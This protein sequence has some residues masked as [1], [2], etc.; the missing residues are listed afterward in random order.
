MVV[1]STGYGVTRPHLCL[2]SVRRQTGVVREH[3]YVDAAQQ[4]PP[5]PALENLLHLTR[6]L[7]PETIV[8][9]L[10]LDDWLARPD[11][12]AMVYEAHADGAWVTYGSY[13]TADGLPGLSAGVNVAACRA[14]PW[15]A[16][17]LKSYRAGL[18]HRIRPADLQDVGGAWLTN[19]RDVAVMLPCLEMAGQDR[20]VFVDE[21]L[22]IYNSA[23]SYEANHGLAGLAAERA[24][25]AYVRGLEPYERLESLAAR[26]APFDEALS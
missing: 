11:A 16:S 15:S 7:S 23:D 3:R 12:L 1:V 17:H 19:A 14:A 4:R 18:L 25:A 22:S 24:A 5:L 2:E 26:G 21:I 13:L 6:G 8:V 20:C 9:S 10:D